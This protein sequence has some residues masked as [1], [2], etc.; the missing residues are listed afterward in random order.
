MARKHDEHSLFELG[1]SLCGDHG[2][3]DISV[4]RAVS[5]SEPIVLPDFK[6][7]FAQFRLKDN[8]KGNRKGGR[9]LVQNPQERGKFENIGNSV[10]KR[11]RNSRHDNL[12]GVRPNDNLICFI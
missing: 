11:D 10:K 7:N 8:R 6:E 1:K 12:H 3:I 4:P 2:S 5:E 9:E